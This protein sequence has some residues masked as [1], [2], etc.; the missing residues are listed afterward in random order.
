M[1]E[2]E[3]KSIVEALLFSSAEPLSLDR[4]KEASGGDPK[5]L[6][7]AIGALS[8][9]YASTGRAFTIDKIAG[10]YQLQSRPEYAPWLEKLHSSRSDGKL[11]PAALETLAII[12]YKQP[13]TRAEIESVRGVQVGPVMQTLVDKDLVRIRGRSEELGHPLLYGTTKRF[14]EVFALDSLKDLPSSE[15]FK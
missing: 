10:G 9:E 6:E 11:S 14:L 15:E 8:Q 2:P 4:M 13:I 7:E 5:S 12:A 1:S 3:L